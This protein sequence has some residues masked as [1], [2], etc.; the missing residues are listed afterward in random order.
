[1]KVHQSQE[2]SAQAKHE[3]GELGAGIFYGEKSQ[4]WGEKQKW[5]LASLRAEWSSALLLRQHG[6][7][8]AHGL[9]PTRHVPR[10]RDVATKSSQGPEKMFP[11]LPASA[12][13]TRRR[14][15]GKGK[16]HAR[17]NTD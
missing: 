12:P 14:L 3:V 17:D 7:W 15:P 5:S 9:G 13:A 2:K 4:V 16:R 11:G 10:E 8:Q 1:M 6:T